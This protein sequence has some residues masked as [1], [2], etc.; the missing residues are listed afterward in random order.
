MNKRRPAKMWIVAGLIGGVLLIATVSIVIQTWSGSNPLASGI[1][2]YERG[3]WSEAL[4]SARRR[5]DAAKSDPAALRLFARA[6]ARLGRDDSAEAIYRRLGTEHMK[7]EDFFLLGRGLLRSG[8]SGPGL[9]SLR[10]A[11]DADPDHAET[12]DALA[13]RYAAAGATAEAADAAERLSRQPGWEVRGRIRLAPLRHGLHDP[14]GAANA[15]RQALAADPRLHDAVMTPAEASKLL[16]VC[17]L[18]SG[19]GGEAGEVLGSIGNTGSTPE[20][21]RLL[22]RVLLQQGKG[23]EAR[24]ALK[25]AGNLDEADPMRPEP[26]PYV[27]TARCAD[28]HARQFESHQ[29]S[30]HTSTIVKTAD[31][32]NIDWPDQ[33]VIDPANPEVRHEFRHRGDRIEVVTNVAGREFRALVE[34]ALGSNH[35]GQSFLATDDQGGTR[36][37]RISRYPSPPLW[38]RT[39]QHPDRPPDAAGYLGR[40]LTTTAAAAGCINCHVTS[41]FASIHPEGRPEAADRGIGCERCHGP[42][43][44]HLLAVE[45]EFPELAIARPRLAGAEQVMTLCGECHKAP[46]G[47]PT[48]KPDFIR[49][50]APNLRM[51]RCYTESDGGM[52]CVTCHDPHRDAVKSA[53]HYEAVCLD[54]HGPK[55][56]PHP[57]CP[58]NSTT[59]CLD[60]HMPRVDDAVPRAV[61]TDHFIRVHGDKSGTT[62]SAQ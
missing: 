5:L 45:A 51:S 22:S 8:R 17:L 49:F 6:S 42:G 41:P 10:A 44:N 39:N 62:A 21:A 19:R 2:A 1:S 26:S 47:S 31:L 20:I 33:P 43:G 50:Q 37:L 35:Q 12:L 7:A 28:C 55:P 46:A 59:K 48:D 58:V 4:A 16:A 53:A 36:E 34:Y 56:R 23:D 57:P 60:C 11:R 52:S 38:D 25:D 29:R 14:A 32:K 3:D 30:R 13:E 54:C 18:E 40:P 27:G 61:F 15:I 24:S 9:V